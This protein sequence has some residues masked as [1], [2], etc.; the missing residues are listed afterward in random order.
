[1]YSIDSV[2]YSGITERG[3]RR[4]A[5]VQVTPLDDRDV[6]LIAYFVKTGID[7][8]EMVEVVRNDSDLAID[9]F[10]NNLHEAYQQISEE[11]FASGGQ[12]DA[13]WQRETFKQEILAYHGIREQ[14]KSNL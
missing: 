6:P 12:T 4:C 8:Y 14:L 1:M 5:A 13:R 7:Q 10:E 3:G 2:K 11:A 9:W